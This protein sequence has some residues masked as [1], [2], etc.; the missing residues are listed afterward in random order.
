MH[1]GQVVLPG[2]PPRSSPSLPVPMSWSSM[3][4]ICAWAD[5][6]LRVAG[7]VAGVP[8]HAA[9]PGSRPRDSVPTRTRSSRA[10]TTWTPP[11][12]PPPPRRIAWKTPERGGKEPGG[13]SELLPNPRSPVVP[14]VGTKGRFG[15]WT[16]PGGK[17]TRRRQLLPRRPAELSEP[18]GNRVE[19]RKLPSFLTASG[20]ST[21][22]P[23]A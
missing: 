1:A 15:P 20:T 12:P 5:M 11:P 3:A 9:S 22:R 14:S 4:R 18:F 19:K 16:P 8:T 7:N 2:P 21:S 10:S 13:G 6:L 17:H 23:C